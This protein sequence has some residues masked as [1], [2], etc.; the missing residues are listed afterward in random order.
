MEIRSD[1]VWQNT[2]AM[3]KRLNFV[4]DLSHGDYENR[5]KFSIFKFVITSLS[6]A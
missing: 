4:I 3:A 2:I 1:K 5:I 6:E